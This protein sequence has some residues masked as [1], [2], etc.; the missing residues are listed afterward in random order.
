MA[1]GVELLISTSIL[2][3]DLASSAATL[4]RTIGLPEPRP[5]W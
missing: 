2:V 1:M 5:H 4:C 3:D